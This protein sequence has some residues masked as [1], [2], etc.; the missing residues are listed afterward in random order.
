MRCRALA[1]ATALAAY[2]RSCPHHGVSQRSPKDLPRDPNKRDGCGSD[3][4]RD[5]PHTMLRCLHSHAGR[6]G[7]LMVLNLHNRYRIED[8][9]ADQWPDL[10][11]E[12]TEKR[13]ADIFTAGRWPRSAGGLWDLTL[14]ARTRCLSIPSPNEDLVER[15]P[16]NLALPPGVGAHAER[17]CPQP[18]R[19]QFLATG[20][21]RA[22]LPL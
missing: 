4:E 3:G 16:R 7:L 10:A 22:S 14:N 15:E 12:V 19:L 9:D 21:R 2:R 6:P 1:E 11:V 13:P 17:V 20:L 5:W 18:Q 8:Q